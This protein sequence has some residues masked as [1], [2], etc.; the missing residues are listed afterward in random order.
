MHPLYGLLRH[1][2]ARP[3]MKEPEIDDG[4]H[5][6]VQKKEKEILLWEWFCDHEMKSW[7]TIP[8]KVVRYCPYCGIEIKE[9]SHE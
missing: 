6:I 2:H 9:D 5:Q 8:P 3:A 7:F 1:P 4:T